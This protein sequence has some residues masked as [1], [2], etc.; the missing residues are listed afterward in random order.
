MTK[1]QEKKEEVDPL[2][3]AK[4]RVLLALFEGANPRG[5]SGP[6]RSAFR[7]LFPEKAKDIY[8]S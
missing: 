8:G 2:A 3:E 5:F 7:E 6:N 4:E 1:K